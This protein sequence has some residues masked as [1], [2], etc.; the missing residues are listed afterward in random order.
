MESPENLPMY[1]LVCLIS[2]R[3]N[4]A[5]SGLISRFSEKTTPWLSLVSDWLVHVAQDC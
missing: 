3:W 4:F 1:N 5:N 2:T